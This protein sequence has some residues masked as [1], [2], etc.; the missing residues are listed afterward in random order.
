T[1]S[2]LLGLI[3]GL[4][5]FLPVSSS[6]HL[7]LLRPILGL[8]DPDLWFDVLLH[9][10][11]LFAVLLFMI[12]QYHRLWKK[13]SIVWYVILAT[14]PA[15]IFGILFESDVENYVRNNY[16]L[17]SIVLITVGFIFFFIKER[18]SRY[19]EEMNWN[20]AL[21]IGFSQALALIPGVSRSGI[22]LIVALLLGFRRE[23][24]VFFSFLLSITTIGGALVKGLMEISSAGLFSWSTVL[25]GF[26]TAFISGLIACLLLL[27]MVQNKELKPFGYYRIIFGVICLIYFLT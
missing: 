10:G 17:I 25:P 23:D 7:I 20:S 9:G 11:T 24:A 18:G 14:I 19:L 3:Q 13:P 1:Q 22:T 5:E 8:G 12:P 4:T 21:L 15:G 26:I 2:I 16:E 6:A 27:R